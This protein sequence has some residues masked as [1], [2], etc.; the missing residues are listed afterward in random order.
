[1]TLPKVTENEPVSSKRGNCAE[2]MSNKTYEEHLREYPYC[3][4]FLT[5]NVRFRLRWD[6]E[7]VNFVSQATHVHTEWRCGSVDRLIIPGQAE[8]ES[9][10][11]SADRAP[12][13]LETD[14]EAHTLL[15]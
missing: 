6:D 15:Q 5:D 1:M 8:A 4:W 11:L 13:N 9:P 14:P 10:A 12:A 2:K 7:R 3:N